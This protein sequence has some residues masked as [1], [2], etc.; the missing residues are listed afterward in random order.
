MNTAPPT[1]KCKL[2]CFDNRSCRYLLRP[3]RTNTPTEWSIPISTRVNSSCSRS[4]D[5]YSSLT[6]RTNSLPLFLISL[7]LFVAPKAPEVSELFFKK[8]EISYAIYE[9]LFVRYSSKEVPSH[10]TDRLTFPVT[11]SRPPDSLTPDPLTTL[12]PFTWGAFVLYGQISCD[13]PPLYDPPVRAQNPKRVNYGGQLWGVQCFKEETPKKNSGSA[14]GSI[15]GGHLRG[16][17]ISPV[18]GVISG[19]G[20]RQ[21]PKVAQHRHIPHKLALFHQPILPILRVLVIF[22]FVLHNVP[23][24]SSCSPLQIRPRATLTPPQSPP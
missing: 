9:Q 21:S 6:Q 12:T 18:Q 20:L 2:E 11:P 3:F 14:G 16:G 15:M 17:S 22:P 4:D 19:G 7:A 10:G 13:Y 23:S 24:L 5:D 8:N 1:S